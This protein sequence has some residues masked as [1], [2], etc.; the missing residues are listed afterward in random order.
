MRRPSVG[1]LMYEKRHLLPL[2]PAE[3]TEVHER[4]FP[5]VTFPTKNSTHHLTPDLEDD[6]SPSELWHSPS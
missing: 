3:E 1:L 4:N 6:D 2:E 5:T